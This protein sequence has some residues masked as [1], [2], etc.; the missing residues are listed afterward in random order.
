MFSSF[1]KSG[2]RVRVI[3]RGA[4]NYFQKM[5]GPKLLPSDQQ[6]ELKKSTDK[7]PLLSVYKALQGQ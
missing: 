6:A 7:T 3:V 1:N 2:S 5:V 4:L